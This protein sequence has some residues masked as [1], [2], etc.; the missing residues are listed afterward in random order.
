MYDAYVSLLPT[1]ANLYFIFQAKMD[2]IDEYLEYQY[3]IM[4]HIQKAGASMSHHHG[5]GKMTAPWL[6]PRSAT[7]RWRFIVRSRS[8]SIRITS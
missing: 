1:G 5:I 3:G 4:D 7:M 8:I 6:E 2:S